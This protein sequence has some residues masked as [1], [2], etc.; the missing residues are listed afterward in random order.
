M[1]GLTVALVLA[2]A[3][4]AFFTAAEAAL[5]SLAES[6]IRGVV[7]EGQR[8]AEALAR[9]RAKPERLLVLLRL[10]DTLAEVVAAAL[11]GFIAYPW[12]G[13]GLAV[14]S[15]AAL[16][17]VLLVGELMPI[18]F[19]VNRALRVALFAAPPLLVLYHLL[20]PILAI[21]D[22]LAHVVPTPEPD[23]TVVGMTESELRQLQA[24]GH[25]EE[26]DE[27]E[28]EIIERAFRL[29]ETKAWD[30]MTPR[31]DIFAWPD[32]MLL[33]A[34]APQLGTVPYSR[35]PVF[36]ET[37]DDITGVLYIRDAYQALVTGQRDVPLRNLAREPLIVPGSVPLSKL[38]R[39]FQTRR[40]HMA[41]VV[42]EYGGTDGLVTLEDVLEELV[43]EIVDETDLAEEP[44]VR[45][46]RHEIIAAGDADLRE[47]N[48]I[49]N[50]A[51]PQLEHRSLNGYLLDELGRV[52]EPGERLQRDGIEIE[53]L[54]ATETQV[55][56][57]RLRRTPATAEGGGDGSAAGPAAEPG[58]A[59]WPPSSGVAEAGRST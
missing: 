39:D 38:L 9:L 48:H 14:A 33:A 42:D 32:S 22:K 52:P 59:A 17:V 6:R 12:G 56:R 49:F 47:I 13:A 57:A 29:D 16:L 24:M 10:G 5:F 36:G 55:I 53:V 11:A 26:I 3:A 41:I 20:T 4:S 1:I 7:A 31:V 37:V 51:L 21:L 34:I 18:R 23:A 43:G 50:I 2:V 35:V 44:I 46:S 15:A 25:G 8:G 28:R 40:I 30:I 45:V 19:A 27:H 58:D 54:E